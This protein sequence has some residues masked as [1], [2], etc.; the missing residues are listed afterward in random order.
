MDKKNKITII[1]WLE[2]GALL[3]NFRNEIAFVAESSVQVTN[4]ILSQFQGFS[5]CLFF[6]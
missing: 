4:Q 6:I 2:N 5:N 3:N 1:F